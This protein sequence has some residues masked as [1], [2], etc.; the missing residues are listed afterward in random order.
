MTHFIRRLWILAG[1]PLA[2]ACAA[3]LAVSGSGESGLAPGRSVTGRLTPA[4]PQFRDG[5]HYR[6]YDF[7]A[8]QGDTLTVALTSDDFDANLILADRFGNPVSRN[9]DGGEHCNARLTYVVRSTGPHRLYANSSAPAE[10]GE[11]RLSITRG[12]GRAPDDTTC[13]SFG[14]VQGMIQAGE[15]VEGELAADDPI[16]SSDSTY[17]QR[18]ILPVIPGQTV[19]IDLQSDS[20]DAYL[21]L[22]RG[23]GDT[24]AENDDG[25]GECNARIVYTATDDR[26]VRIVVN[27]V[28]RRETGRFTL[29]VST[30]ALRI[31]PKG[32]C[33]DDDAWSG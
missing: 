14:R 33:P 4:D 31:D 10:L 26:P 27:T 8:R 29:R 21:L 7:T 20:F 17:F 5:S 9:D 11:Y 13:R 30:G 25:G 24:L 22:T 15:M 19:T 16:F 3:G 1:A 2:A 32:D 12:R 18:W 28:K 6:R 23:R